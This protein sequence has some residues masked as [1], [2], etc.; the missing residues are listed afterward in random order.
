MRTTHMTQC[1]NRALIPGLCIH[2]KLLSEHVQ[3]AIS[4]SINHIHRITCSMRHASLLTVVS[5]SP[6]VPASYELSMHYEILCFAVLRYFKLARPCCVF[7]CI[8]ICVADSISQLE[9]PRPT[10]QRHAYITQACGQPG[11]V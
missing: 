1:Y 11:S 2:L 7:A 6:E 10:Q 4:I 8:Y 9:G 3:S 5:R